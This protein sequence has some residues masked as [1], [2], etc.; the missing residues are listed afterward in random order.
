[1]AHLV[2]HNGECHFRGSVNDRDDVRIAGLIADTCPDY[3]L[4]EDD[5]DYCD[6][7][8]TCF[9]CRYRRWLAEGFSCVRGHLSL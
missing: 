1:M 9:N 4:D 2:E 5:E 7:T 8:R 3:S 6:G